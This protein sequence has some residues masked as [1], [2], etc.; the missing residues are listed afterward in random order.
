ME[1]FLSAN[2][3]QVFHLVTQCTTLSTLKLNER[4]VKSK[5]YKQH[6]TYILIDLESMFHEK[7]QNHVLGAFKT[8]KLS[9]NREPYK[10]LVIEC[11]G[12][13]TRADDEYDLV[14]RLSD[15]L[16]ENE[17]KKLII[18]AKNGENIA[19]DFVRRFKH[20]FQ[21]KEDHT[22]FEDLTEESQEK[23]LEQKVN[24]QGANVRLNQLINRDSVIENGI[25]EPDVMS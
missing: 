19:K 8:T 17:A 4:L 7:I 20:K 5:K 3:P 23:L 1:G 21:S 13:N 18:I 25:I 15:I 22:S 10:L 6:D 9:K 14:E 24:F 16:K 11:Q 12:R 2:K